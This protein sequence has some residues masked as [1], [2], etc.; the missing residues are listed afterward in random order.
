MGILVIDPGLSTTVQDAGRPGYREW[1]VPLSGAFDRGSADMANALLGNSPDCAVLELTLSG[2]MYQA[3]GPMAL[4]LTGAP[5]EAKIL[6]LDSTEH[7]LQLPLSF[8]LL[9]GDRLVLGRTHIGART[10]LAVK[11]GWRTRLHLGSRSSEQ[12][13]RAGEILPADAGT[14]PTRRPCEPAWRSP[15]DEPFRIIEGPDGRSLSDFDDAF[16]ADRRFRVGSRSDRMG[17]RLEGDPVPVAFAPERLSTPVSP[18]AIQVAGGQ[19]IVLGV[20]CGTMGGY[21]H[22][23]HVIS[24]DLDRLGQLKP[25]DS[26]AFRRVIVEEARSLDQS[27]R[28]ARKALIHRLAT[29]AEDA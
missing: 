19:L 20:A 6:R 21:P 11:G 22:V 25:G 3:E 14:I 8:S 1:G 24:A 2:G 7:A 26:V 27:A 9:D 10:Y 13:V 28:Q 5:M 18:G 15:I 29:L 23:A 16:G 17:L 12:R 4:A